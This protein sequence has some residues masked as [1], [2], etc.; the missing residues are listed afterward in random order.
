MHGAFAG[1][2]DIT[3]GLVNT[4][5]VFLPVRPG[6][7]RSSCLHVGAT[8]NTGLDGQVEAVWRGSVMRS[9]S[10]PADPHHHPSAAQGARAR[11]L[12]TP[13]AWLGDCAAVLRGVLPLTAGPG[14]GMPAGLAARHA[15]DSAASSRAQ[16]NPKGGRWIW[17]V[18]SFVLQYLLC[19]SY[20]F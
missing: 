1:F 15:H 3:V 11:N 13:H 10:P 4:H 20:G 19:L 5:Y 16:V 2:T 7:P 9:P 8:G 12:R 14:S 18:N 17:L 6:G